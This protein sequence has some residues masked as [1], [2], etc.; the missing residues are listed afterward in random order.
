LGLHEAL[1]TCGLLRTRTMV[2]VPA[3]A[4]VAETGWDVTQPRIGHNETD[5]RRGGRLVDGVL[6]FRRVAP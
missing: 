1:A 4:D 6:N 2:V 3:A 5:T